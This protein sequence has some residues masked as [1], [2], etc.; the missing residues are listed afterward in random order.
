MIEPYI[1][2]ADAEV[3]IT[4]VMCSSIGKHIEV[5]GLRTTL[6]I[7]IDHSGPQIAASVRSALTH[8]LVGEIFTQDGQAYILENADDLSTHAGT[9]SQA[10]AR[11]AVDVVSLILAHSACEDT[12]ME[13]I[14]LSAYLDPNTAS[15]TLDALKVSLGELDRL[16]IE[17]VIRDRLDSSLN[18][19]R[20]EGL[21]NKFD[22]LNAICGGVLPSKH[23]TFEISR[24]RIE[25]LDDRRHEVAHRTVPKVVL[26]NG[27]EDIEY[28]FQ[29][30]TAAVFNICRAFDL[31][32]DEAVID[33]ERHLMFT[34]TFQ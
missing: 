16:G 32:L 25:E 17:A 6:N 30:A 24:E 20:K 34:G 11:R 13:C 12:L 1:S 22:R 14:E 29:I 10:K 15:K 33:S 3:R 4:R 9:E 19:L 21:L 28:L 27:D 7:A 31:K 8:E 5:V 18:K 2:K 26:K 23:R